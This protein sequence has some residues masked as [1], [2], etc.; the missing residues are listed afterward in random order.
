MPDIATG[1]SRPRVSA[2]TTGREGTRRQDYPTLHNRAVVRRS[3]DPGDRF[4]HRRALAPGVSVGGRSSG[5]QHGNRPDPQDPQLCRRAGNPARWPEHNGGG[6][7]GDTRAGDCGNGGGTGAGVH[8]GGHVDRLRDSRFPGAAGDLEAASAGAVP[9]LRRLG[10]GA[11]RALA[12]QGRRTP[13]VCPGAAQRRPSGAGRAGATRQAGYPG[14]PE[15]GW[16]A[17]GCRGT[18]PSGS[19]NCTAPTGRWSA[20]R[21]GRAAQR[22]RRWRNSRPPATARAAGRAAVSSR[23]R[24]CRSVSRCRRTSLQ[25]AFRAAR[26]ADVVL[27]AGST[28]EVQPAADVPLAATGTGAR[29]AIIN[30]GP[31]AHDRFRRPAPGGRRDGAAARAGA[32]RQSRAAGRGSRVPQREKLMADRKRPSFTATE[33]ARPRR[34]RDA[35]GVP[36]RRRGQWIQAG[37]AAVP[38]RRRRS[39]PRTA[40]RISP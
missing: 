39:P 15:R 11:P 7:S 3:S 4:A 35:P 18:I 5:R 8:R 21:A 28:L 38:T 19:S 17:S 22:S 26:R 13:G 14:D 32:R 2:L 31:T 16:P 37:P 1:T 34:P 6:R 10:R 20:C 40:S 29:Y 12:V 27:A 23:R 30:R 24:R 25:R 36:P 9:G 33:R